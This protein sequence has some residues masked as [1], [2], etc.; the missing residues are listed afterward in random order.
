MKKLSYVKNVLLDRSGCA[1]PFGLLKN[2]IHPNVTPS[3]IYPTQPA[4]AIFPKNYGF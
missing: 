4:A 1:L 2:P 3:E